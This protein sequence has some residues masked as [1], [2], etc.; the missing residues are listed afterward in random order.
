M[1]AASAIGPGAGR[2]ASRRAG[3][4]DP[5]QG[6]LRALARQGGRRLRAGRRADRRQQDLGGEAEHQRAQRPGDRRLEFDRDAGLRRYPPAHVAGLPAQRA[7]GRLAGGLSQRRAAQ[8]RRHHDAGRRLC[9]RSGQRARRD[10]RRASPACSTGRTSRIR[11]QHTD[12]CIKGLQDSGVRAVF[13]YGAGQNETGRVME[14]ANGQIS[15]RHRAAAQAVFLQRRSA[16]H[17]LSWRRSAARPKR[18]SSQ[19]KAARD[20]GARITIHV[21]VGEFGRNALLE[22]LH[23]VERAQGRTPPTST[24]ARSTTPNG[25]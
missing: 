18:R 9:R 3:P 11:P 20:V 4:A 23:A 13:A 10:R 25:S 16:R 15:R 5:A 7:A 6:R 21:G 12:A 24:A 19:F 2:A 14:I 8:V 17:A 1:L 22:K